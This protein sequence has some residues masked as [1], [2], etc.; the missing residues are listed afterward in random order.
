MKNKGYKLPVLALVFALALCLALGA[1]A[2]SAFPVTVRDALGREVAIDQEPQRLVSGY[3]ISTSMLMALDRTD[4]LVGIE[5]KAAQRPI[6]ALAAPQLLSLP[7]VG[8]AKSFDLEGCAALEPDLVV[9]PVKLKD[10]IPALEALGIPAIAINPES[11]E[12]MGETLALLGAATGAQ[13]RA[14]ALLADQAQ[15][16]EQLGALLEGAEQPRVYLAG[17]SSYLNTAGAKM[18]QHALI[19]MGGGENVAAAL[20]D[21]Y[22]ATVSYE[23]LLA[24][25]P[26]AIVIVPEAD[27]TREDLMADAQLADLRAVREG[28]VYAMPDTVEAWDS[29]VPAMT[30][31]SLWMAGA[32]HPDRYADFASDALAFY[33][34]F[35]GIELDPALLA[36]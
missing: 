4:R 5:A 24:W 3:Y 28:R 6:Y 21:S 17:N 11:F 14:D 22:W 34:T 8:T 20:E 12:Q 23:Q 1:L 30:L 32:L 36:Q 19:G 26:D 25:D 9:L 13:E 35:Y 2:E 16:L 31:G 29:P 18:A 7:N 33:R 15:K 10:V 27:Y